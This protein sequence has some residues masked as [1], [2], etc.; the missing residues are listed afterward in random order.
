[1]KRASSLGEG[2]LSVDLYGRLILD[3]EKR[4]VLEEV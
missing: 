2:L 1:M 4:N 3:C